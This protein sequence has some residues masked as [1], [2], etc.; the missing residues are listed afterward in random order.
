MVLNSININCFREEDMKG[1]KC[2]DPRWR[3]YRQPLSVQVKVSSVMFARFAF[4]SIFCLFVWGG[5]WPLVN[6]EILKQRGQMEE[7][8]QGNAQVTQVNQLIFLN[9][10]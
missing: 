10:C 2:D 6:I 8:G 1:K 3:S 7:S 4:Y 5:R 9:K